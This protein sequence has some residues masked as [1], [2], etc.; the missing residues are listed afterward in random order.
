MNRRVA[1]IAG[2][3]VLTI[4]V[5]IG[6][7]LG[8]QVHTIGQFLVTVAVAVLGTLLGVVVWYLIDGWEEV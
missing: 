1:N 5:L 6:V 7:L 4:T 8:I 3:T 2:G